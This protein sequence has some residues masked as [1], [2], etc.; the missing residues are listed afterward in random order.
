MLNTIKSCT[1][2][3]VT[4]TS[5]GVGKTADDQ[6]KILFKTI[7]YAKWTENGIIEDFEN[8]ADS[9]YD[10]GDDYEY[11]KPGT[12]GY[13]A[14]Y[15]RSGMT[16]IHRIG[17]KSEEQDFLLNYEKM[18]EIGKT[19]KLS[20]WVTTDKEN[21]KATLSLV[22]EEFPDIFDNDLGVEEIKVLEG[23][24]DGKWQLVEVTFTAKTK[25]I[26]IRTSGD[27]SLFFD[28]AMIL[29][30]DEKVDVPSTNN[31]GTDNGFNIVPIII[32]AAVVIILLIVGAIVAIIIIKKKK[33]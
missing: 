2:I 14:K 6:I 17:A 28:D 12:S 21:T 20:F 15:V 3:E 19:Y 7:L 22:H 13:N 1:V 18:L 4:N 24:K 32:I 5:V 10:Y 23:M 27:A 26:A 29:P 9:I 11:Y 16:A 31:N 33:A 8:Y 30:T 25:W